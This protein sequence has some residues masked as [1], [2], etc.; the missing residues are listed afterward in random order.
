[1]AKIAFAHD[2]NSVVHGKYEALVKLASES[3]LVL[4]VLRCDQDTPLIIGELDLHRLGLRRARYWARLWFYTDSA[5]V[6]DMCSLVGAVLDDLTDEETRP[7]MLECHYGFD[8]PQTKRRAMICH[9]RTI[10]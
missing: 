7:T 6:D 9:E 3:S 8:D 5:P 4:F 2:R 10:G 1:M